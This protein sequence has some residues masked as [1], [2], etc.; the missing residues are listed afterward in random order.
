MIFVCSDYFYNNKDN[1]RMCYQVKLIHK[2]KGYFTV[3]TWSDLFYY[4]KQ[5]KKINVIS[6]HRKNIQ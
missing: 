1:N 6:L 5:H 2:I 3:F 4:L